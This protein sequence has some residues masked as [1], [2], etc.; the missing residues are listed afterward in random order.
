LTCAD[1]FRRVA[2]HVGRWTAPERRRPSVALFVHAVIWS[3]VQK[4]LKSK[5]LAGHTFTAFEMIPPFAEYQVQK[6]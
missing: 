3:F 1:I 2:A 5:F 4:F 6:K